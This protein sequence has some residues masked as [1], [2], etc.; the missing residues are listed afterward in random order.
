[1]DGRAYTVLLTFLVPAVLIGVTI[2]KYA[3]NPL[4]LLILFSV[5]IAGGLY[6]LTY[7]ETFRS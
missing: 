6:L 5:M 1:M 3:A 2:W 4:A 7:S